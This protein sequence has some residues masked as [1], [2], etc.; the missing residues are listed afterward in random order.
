MDNIEKGAINPIH[1]EDTKQTR[2]LPPSPTASQEKTEQ[3]AANLITGNY[4]KT[5]TST[6]APAGLRDKALDVV[7]KKSRN[8]SEMSSDIKLGLIAAA[9]AMPGR[10]AGVSV[11]RL[12]TSLAF[13][14]LFKGDPSRL[15]QV[16]VFLENLDDEGFKNFY[17]Q[18]GRDP[19][20]ASEESP[21]TFTDD[22]LLF[23]SAFGGFGSKYEDIFSKYAETNDLV[24]S[25]SISKAGRNYFIQMLSIFHDFNAGDSKGI[26][27]FM[28]LIDNREI[29][30]VKVF[31]ESLGDKVNLFNKDANGRT[32][33][34]HAISSGNPEIA[35]EVI[36]VYQKHA[37]K[38]ET[39]EELAAIN[40]EFFMAVGYLLRETAHRTPTEQAAQLPLI[41]ELIKANPSIIDFSNQTELGLPKGTTLLMLAALFPNEGVIKLLLDNGAHPRAQNEHGQ[42]ALRVYEAERVQKKE[43]PAIKALLENAMKTH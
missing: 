32:A 24:S 39:P 43:N 30:G 23:I 12:K 19:I 20:V 17:K 27:P 33:L 38:A 37:E 13:E 36:H 28:K 40:M 18:L 14:H 7:A 22:V 6:P 16:N 2:S 42:N 1:F 8:L 29:K 3:A 26:T 10:G 34:L 11:Y 5:E 4:T 41:S 15:Y 35:S 25:H 9:E 21:Y 31:L